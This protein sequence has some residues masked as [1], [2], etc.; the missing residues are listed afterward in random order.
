MDVNL[1]LMI[2]SNCNDIRRGPVAHPCGAR[3][4]PLLVFG[5]AATLCAVRKGCVAQRLAL[6]LRHV[7]LKLISLEGRATR[8]FSQPKW[9]GPIGRS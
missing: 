4:R 9:R 8:A 5:A 1:P 3:N 7:T 2:K 6:P